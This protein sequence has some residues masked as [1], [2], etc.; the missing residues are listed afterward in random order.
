MKIY[1]ILLQL[2][3]LVSCS[4]AINNQ[5][6]ERNPASPSG[7][8]NCQLIVQS[9]FNAKP[10]ES[11]AKL[12]SS[13]KHYDS[14]NPENKKIISRLVRWTRDV[15]S[16]SNSYSDKII[17]TF[18]SL[19]FIDYKHSFDS[20]YKAAK[21]QIKLD[22]T[23][24]QKLYGKSFDNYKKASAFLLKD[25]PPFTLDTIKKTHKLMMD[26]GIDN[27]PSETIGKMR[28]VDMVGNVTKG[29]PQ[30]A[31]DEINKNIYLSSEGLIK[32]AMT[33]KYTG[34]I[35]Y[36]TI[37]KMRPELAEKLKD[38]A[39]QLFDDI[40]KFNTQNIGNQQDLTAKFV[41]ALSEDLMR[42]FVKQKDDLGEINTAEKLYAYTRA[43]AIFQKGLISIH[44]FRDG[45]GRTIRQFAIYHAF[46]SIG[47]PRPRLVDPDDDLYTSVDSWTE[48]LLDG[49]R[50][51]QRLYENAEKRLSQ[52]LPLETTP[53]LL[54]A[55]FKEAE[56]INL[57]Q[58]KPEKLTLNY[59]DSEVDINQIHTFFL[60]KLENPE[61]RK[62]ISEEPSVAY[63]EILKDYYSFYKKNRID[64]IHEKKGLEHLS[65]NFIDSDFIAT[66]ANRSYK[67]TFAWKEKMA[68]WYTDTT[69][70]RGL[71]RQDQEIEENEILGMFKAVNKQ[72]VSNNVGK[73]ISS[74]MTSKQVNE[75]VFQDFSQ[76]NKD[77]L[78]NGL[79]KMAKD[80]SETG[81]MYGHS[82]GYSTSSKREV[83]KAFAM[84]AMVVAPYGQHQEFQHLLKSRVLVGM[85]AGKKDVVLARLK[86]MRPEFS[87]IYPRQQEIMG[88]GAADPDSVM[89]VQL[90]DESG[91]VIKSY[92][93]NPN[94]PS[95]IIVIKKEINSVEELEEIDFENAQKIVLD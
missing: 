40:H 12:E 56:K 94:N 63:N 61:M 38:I 44:P 78:T 72:F 5:L 49:I 24:I 10:A 52:G 47:F 75:I 20:L 77:L 58:Q 42:W 70:W 13:L 57:K 79:E 26:G 30:D 2:T 73:K 22:D 91:E 25:Q 39:P 29:I 6:S 81:P 7:S 45:N 3:I 80:H 83:G 88:I 43:V 87:Y 9:F 50:N 74:S 51:T 60:L 69:V 23:N 64:Y 89:F 14:V 4:T 53:E 93:R 37:K 18:D 95:E 17:D 66:F 84:G 90:I 59:K 1:F 35:Y 16:T 41:T 33:G 67:K 76:Y 54:V 11:K 15:F 55:R 68:K 27:I 62:R 65:V 28:V 71:S 46:D 92:V 86:Q 82:Y 48:S 32:D 31:I 21:N 8:E 85:K 19:L 36:P 34:R